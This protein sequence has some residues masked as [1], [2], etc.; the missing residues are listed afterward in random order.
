M[1]A[2]VLI[3]EDEPFLR[4]Y[5]ADIALEAGFDVLEAGSAE[6]AIAILEARADVRIVFTDIRCRGPWTVSSWPTPSATAGRPC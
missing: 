3:V 2:T 1:S 6:E 4:F 5:A